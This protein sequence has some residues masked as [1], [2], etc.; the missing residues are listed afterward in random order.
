MK[1]REKNNLRDPWLVA[2]WPGMGQV[3]AGAGSYLAQV[4]KP[5]PAGRIPEHEFF[6]INQVD[7]S[8]GIARTG[9]LPQS[10]FFAW[11]DPKGRRD[12]VFFIGGAAGTGEPIRKR[13]NETL[14]FSKMTF[15]H[16]LAQ[17]IILEQLYRACTIL[18]GEP[19]HK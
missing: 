14:S 11:R 15:P 13:A 4:L 3:A 8:D 9:R 16:E 17:V 1:R 12:L 18:R 10:V 6:S 7:V 19:Y 5:D 2:V